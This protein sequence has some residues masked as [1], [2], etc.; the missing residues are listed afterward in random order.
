MLLCEFELS[1]TFLIEVDEEEGPDRVLHKLIRLSLRLQ[2]TLQQ[3][4]GSPHE[5]DVGHVVILY[6]F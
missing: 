1:R 4:Q 6:G 2:R 5:D 3:S